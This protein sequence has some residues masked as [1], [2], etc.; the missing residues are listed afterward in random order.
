MRVSVVTP[1]FNQAR[2][3]ERTIRSVIHQDH[4]DLEYIVMDGGSTDGTVSILEEYSDR[5]IWRS[6]KDEGQSHAINKGLMMATGEIVAYLNSDDTYE[7]G[8]LSRV[9]EFFE[10]NPERKWVYGKCRI[11]DEADHEIRKAITFYKNLLSMRYSYRKLLSENFICQPA[12]FWKRDLLAEIGYLNEAEGFCMDY[13]FWLR[14]GR[15]YAPGVIDEYL[16]NFRY[17][18][19][20][21]S[22]RGIERQ[23]QDELRLAREY[24]KEHRLA[25]FVHRINYHKILWVYRLLNARP[26]S[27]RN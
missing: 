17:Y 20:N 27:N 7:P 16:A 4:P 14:V 8:A 2:F 9:V 21:K 3:I 25:L 11:V 13:E 18:P 6:E 19:D 24:G 1:S 15:R 26:S 23:F 10:K 5:I 22:W 12:T